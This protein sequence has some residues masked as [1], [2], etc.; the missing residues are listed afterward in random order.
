[1]IL[2]VQRHNEVVE[3]FDELVQKHDKS[4][5]PPPSTQPQPAVPTPRPVPQTAPVSGSNLFSNNTV[6]AP[7]LSNRSISIHAAPQPAPT[8]KEEEDKKKE[9]STG[10]KVGFGLLAVFFSGVATYFTKTWSLASEAL[11]KAE[12]FK[13]EKFTPYV[14][15]LNEGYTVETENLRKLLDREISILQVNNTKA[16]HQTLS[17]MVILASTVAV[18]VSKVYTIL[19]L[20]K[21]ALIA[22][23]AAGSFAMASFVWHS[24]E[25]T[26]IPT[27]IVR[28]AKSSLGTLK[29]ETVAKDIANLL[30]LQP[31]RPQPVVQQSYQRLNEDPPSYAE[32]VRQPA[33]PTPTRCDVDCK[34][35]EDLDANTKPAVVITNPSAPPASQLD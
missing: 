1:M 4:Y 33:V 18:F 8:P 28:N 3:F 23:V 35:Q 10:E 15:D 31:E 17:A 27:R 25:S 5:T 7:D 29:E 11:T 19:W 9:A 13:Q 21:I 26:T 30:N 32:A 14:T 12:K 20:P 24:F 34:T 22:A 6:F 2:P 16:K